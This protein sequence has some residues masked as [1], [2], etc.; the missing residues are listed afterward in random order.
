[1]D[2]SLTLGARTVRLAGPSRSFG[3]PTAADPV[4]H[5]IW[6]RTLPLPFNGDVAEIWL[7]D[8]LDEAV[9]ANNLGVPDILA[10]AMQ[11]LRGAPALGDGGIQIAGAAEYGPLVGGARQEGSDFSDYL[12]ISWQYPDGS[13][14]PPEAAQFR[15]LDCSGFMRMVWGYRHHMVGSDFEDRVALC[16]APLP[17]R[18]AIPRRAYE[19][20]TNGPGIVSVER[21][22]EGSA[23]ISSVRVGDLVFF[24][25]DSGDGEEIDHVGMFLGTDDGGHAR[26]ISSRKRHNGPTMGDY[27]GRSILDGSGL[28]ARAFAG[29]RRL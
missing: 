2:R 6:V 7:H 22:Q 29:A 9:A 18:S 1:M 26:F 3:E 28:Y 17:D 11:Y 10:L 8:W 27:G 21:P 13:W 19:I 20:F 14:D 4:R 15:C 24:D 5:R 16:R 23:D 25:A 12:G